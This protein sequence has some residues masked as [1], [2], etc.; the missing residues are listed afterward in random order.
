[1][2]RIMAARLAM[3]FELGLFVGAQH[4]RTEGERP[5]GGLILELEPY[6]HQRFLSDLSGNDFEAHAGKPEEAVA[7]VRKFLSGH[8]EAPVPGRDQILRDYEAR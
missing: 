7:A 5:R 6:Q 8:S 2:V 3:P 4:Y 1:M